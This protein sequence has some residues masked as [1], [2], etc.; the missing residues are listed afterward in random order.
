MMPVIIP[1]L[2]AVLLGP[3]V[4]Q[5]YNKQ[6]KKGFILIGMSV[7]LLLAFSIWLSRAS[8]GY[9]PP[10]INTINRDL[11]RD[12]IQKH[13][14]KDHPVTFYA[15]EAFLGVLWAYGIVDAYLGG[16]RRRRR[17][18]NSKGGSLV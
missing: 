6:Y 13:I 7:G 15:Y 4:G 18:D 1:V 5:L 3:G 11:L 9:L 12:I 10:D 17:P 14:V 8:L 2:L 16:M